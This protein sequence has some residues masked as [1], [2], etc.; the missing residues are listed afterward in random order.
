MIV[1]FLLT[2]VASMSAIAPSHQNLLSDTGRLQCSQFSEI[3]NDSSNVMVGTQVTIFT[4]GLASSYQDWINP[5]TTRDG[6]VYENHDYLPFKL[7]DEVYY[8]NN[9]KELFKFH[10]PDENHYYLSNEEESIDI[11]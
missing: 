8:I 3:V 7:S 6:T 5:D 2:L 10:F 11:T 9:D 4:H 1:S